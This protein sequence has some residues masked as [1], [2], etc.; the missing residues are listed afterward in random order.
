MVPTR[1]CGKVRE[2]TNSEDWVE[3]K[4][5]KNGEKNF[6]LVLHATDVVA[7]HGSL[8]WNI[9]ENGWAPV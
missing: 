3:Q 4:L 1:S 2:L 5:G 7:R 8:L 9:M 6:D